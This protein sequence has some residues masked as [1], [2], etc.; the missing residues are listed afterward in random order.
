M[1]LRRKLQ[2]MHYMKHVCNNK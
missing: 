1:L 2:R